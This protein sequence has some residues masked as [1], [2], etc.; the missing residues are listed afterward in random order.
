M[1]FFS[2]IWYLQDFCYIAIANWPHRNSTQENQ[3]QVAHRRKLI[4]YIEGNCKEKIKVYM[5]SRVAYMIVNVFSIHDECFK[6]SKWSK[7]TG[8]SRLEKRVR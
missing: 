2:Q 7:Y 3:G 5:K 6:R 4:I 1:N 8:S